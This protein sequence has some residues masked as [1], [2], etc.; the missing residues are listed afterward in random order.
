MYS[1]W[2]VCEWGPV[3]HSETSS[4]TIDNDLWCVPFPE[5]R[6]FGHDDA[7]NW[8]CPQASKGANEKGD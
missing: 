1:A 4:V 7:F 3:P 5:A 8:P 2:S 6:L